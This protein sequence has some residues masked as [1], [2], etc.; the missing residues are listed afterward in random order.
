M[1]ATR[2][3]LGWL[4]DDG[5]WVGRRPRGGGGGGYTIVTHHPSG[6]VTGMTSC[7]A[8]TSAAQKPWEHPPGKAIR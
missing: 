3:G 8:Q 4:W 5:R 1:P 2:K 6:V 7:H